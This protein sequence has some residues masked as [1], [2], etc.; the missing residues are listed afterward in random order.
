MDLSRQGR[1]LKAD[2]M[3]EKVSEHTRELINGVLKLD[4]NNSCLT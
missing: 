3:V 4:K 1:Q 2:T